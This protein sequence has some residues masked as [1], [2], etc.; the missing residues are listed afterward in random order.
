MQRLNLFKTTEFRVLLD[1]PYT[2]ADVHLTLAN[3]SAAA[4]GAQPVYTTPAYKAAQFAN[5]PIVLG[6]SGH[7]VPTG[8]DNDWFDRLVITTTVVAVDPA[9]GAAF[10]WRGDLLGANGAKIVTD[11]AAGQLTAGSTLTF[12]FS[13]PT[14]RQAGVD[15]PYTLS[16][17][18]IRSQSA[19]T[20]TATL[21]G[22]YTTPPWGATNFEP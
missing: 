21:A 18:T 17:V 6:G 9:A 1:G 16:S 4:V 2:L 5:V 15:G 7:A 10:T 13:G 8:K 20:L 14:I 12:T 22:L 11:R 3:G 19:P